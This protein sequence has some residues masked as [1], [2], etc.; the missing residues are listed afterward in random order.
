MEIENEEKKKQA[1]REL[2]KT[3]FGIEK[4]MLSKYTKVVSNMEDLIEQL[5]CVFSSDT[6]NIE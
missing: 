3:F 1:L 4:P 5:H 6:V 2:T